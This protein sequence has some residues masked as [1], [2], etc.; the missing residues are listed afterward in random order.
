MKLLW[1]LICMELL[2]KLLC[3]MEVN[4]NGTLME[5]NMFYV[6]QYLGILKTN[7]NVLCHVNIKQFEMQF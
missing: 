5:V 7:H 2:W 1:K 3:F 6:S 4:M